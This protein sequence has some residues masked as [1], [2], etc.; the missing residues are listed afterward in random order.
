MAVTC[1]DQYSY[2]ALLRSLPDL[3]G[4]TREESSQKIVHKPIIPDAVGQ[5]G[6]ADLVDLQMVPDN[7]Y[8][9][10]LNYQYRL[11]KY[12]ILRPLKT[13]TVAEVADCLVSIFF[14]H[15]PPSILH[16]DNGTEFSNK[17]LM[18]RINELWK[19]TKIVHGR[20]RH[21]QDQA[22][23][24]RANGD[25]KNMLYARLRDVKKECSQWVSELPHVQY[26]KNTAF[27]SGINYTPFSVYFWVETSGPCCRFDTAQSDSVRSGDR[28]STG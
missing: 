27:H 16:T 22:S 10:I 11:S 24:E 26:S 13:K 8:K 19:G 21:P 18:A 1:L 5:R 4:D 6:Q 14:E 25:F 2:T 12:V 9:F 17:T 3:S 7:G 23:V 20:P 15:G 28:G